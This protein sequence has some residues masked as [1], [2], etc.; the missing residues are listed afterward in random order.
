MSKA[1]VHPT[2]NYNA[3]VKLVVNFSVGSSLSSVQ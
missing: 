3:E 1:L 2:Y